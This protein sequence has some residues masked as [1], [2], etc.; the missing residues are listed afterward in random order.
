MALVKKSSMSSGAAKPAVFSAA[1]KSATPVTPKLKP[2]AGKQGARPSRHATASERIAAATEEL[3]SGLAQAAAATK[4]LGRS[5]EQV[6]GG[7][8]EAAGAAQEQ[9]SS[10]KAIVANLT[11]ARGQ[12]DASSRRTE[13]VAISLAEAS[14]QILASVRAIERG[15]ERQSESVAHI[16][17]LDRRAKDIGEITRAVSRISDQTNLLA[18]NAAIEAARAGAHG[19]GFAVVADEVRTLAETSD[20]SAREVQSLTAAMQKEVTE[21]GDALTLAADKARKEARVAASVA[22]ALE[23]RREEMVQIADDSRTILT[24]A[25]EA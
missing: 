6:A 13:T 5:M 10:I 4:Q 21:V 3:A 23:A 18:L 19:R 7:A 11:A 24:A 25:L 14:A 17:V 20:K 2:S 15:A 8:E 9:S 16:E 22:E 1:A 12:A